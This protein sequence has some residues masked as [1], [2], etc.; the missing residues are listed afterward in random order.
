MG[1]NAGSDT[2]VL[3][4]SRVAEYDEALTLRLKSIL[5]LALERKATGRGCV[6]RPEADIGLIGLMCILHHLE[7]KAGW[8]R[9]AAIT[10][11]HVLDYILRHVGDVCWRF[12]WLHPVHEDPLVVPKGKGAD[13]TSAE[14]SNLLSLF[15][16]SADDLEEYAL[17]RAELLLRYADAEILVGTPPQ[18]RFYGDD[19]RGTTLPPLSATF[20]APYWNHEKVQPWPEKSKVFRERVANALLHTLSDVF[21][22]SAW[23]AYIRREVLSNSDFAPG[24]QYDPMVRDTYSVLSGI[25]TFPL[26]LLGVE[27]Y[28]RI[29]RA[30]D[31]AQSLLAACMGLSRI[32]SAVTTWTNRTSGFDS[33]FAPL[34]AGD[35][36][37]LQLWSDRLTGIRTKP[38]EAYCLTKL[39]EAYIKNA[40]APIDQFMAGVKGKA[41]EALA[42]CIDGL[43]NQ[44]MDQIDKG[45]K[46]VLQN[47]ARTIWLMWGED[48]SID[49]CIPAIA[50]Q[51]EALR[52]GLDIAIS[53]AKNNDEELVR[54]PDPAEPHLSFCAYP[55]VDLVCLHDGLAWPSLFLGTPIRHLKGQ[56]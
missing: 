39:F 30:P 28:D 7:P 25:V 56:P 40:G 33:C 38:K 18:L 44:D 16:D 3:D 22:T 55:G 17:V 23:V 13:A 51:R 29:F 50:I 14:V 1:A 2:L 11:V 34:M 43:I 21:G 42:S 20:P 5:Q 41:Y 19:V 12:D 53:K 32:Q 26:K 31:S 8:A 36:A 27:F 52:R 15:R 9:K 4:G 35:R 54:L 10:Y 45:V 47:Y 6:T 37:Q 46:G 24:A 48:K 49:L